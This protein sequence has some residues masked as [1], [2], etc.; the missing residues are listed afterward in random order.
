MEEAGEAG[1]DQPSRNAVS[2]VM[3]EHTKGVKQT[4]ELSLAPVGAESVGA[5]NLALTARGRGCLTANKF[6]WFR[7]YLSNYLG[8]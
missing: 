3:V 2:E 4:Q 8:T 1:Q 7:D 5:V 6:K